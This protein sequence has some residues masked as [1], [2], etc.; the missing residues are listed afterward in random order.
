[1]MVKLDLA[2]G[3]TAIRVA[4]AILIG[5]PTYQLVNDNSEMQRYTAEL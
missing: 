5:R 2:T 3:R 1:M 4:L